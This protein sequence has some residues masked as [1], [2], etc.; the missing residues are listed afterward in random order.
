MT[1]AVSCHCACRVV[2][3][4][5]RLPSGELLPLLR[6]YPALALLAAEYVKFKAVFSFNGDT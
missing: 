6:M 5:T 2:S 3:F 4:P 1:R